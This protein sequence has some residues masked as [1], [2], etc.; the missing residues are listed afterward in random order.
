[1]SNEVTKVP[2]LQRKREDGA[3]LPPLLPFVCRRVVAAVDV[4]VTSIAVMVMFVAGSSVMAPDMSPITFQETIGEVISCGEDEKGLPTITLDVGVN[5]E[6]EVVEVT[7]KK[8]QNEWVNVADTTV[9]VAGSTHT[10][11]D[12][13]IR[14]QTLGNEVEGQEVTVGKW[15]PSLK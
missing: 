10:S 14:D 9:S 1:M 6:G 15:I 2:F 11:L 5:G 3:L 7:Y 8:C 12:N 13:V 4:L